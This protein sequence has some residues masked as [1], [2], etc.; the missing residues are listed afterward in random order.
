MNM[1]L[2][3][4]EKKTIQIVAQLLKKGG[5]SMD[6]LRLTKLMYLIDREALLRW[7]MPLTGDDYA[8]MEFG[9]VLSE[10][11]KLTKRRFLG[12]RLWYDYIS[13]EDGNYTISLLAD[14]S[15][16]E[17]SEEDLDLIDEI[18]T[19]YERKSN[20]F[21]VNTVHHQLPEWEN[22]GKSSKMIATD[23]HKAL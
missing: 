2:K 20:Y 8:S 1:D 16:G 6:M 7:G 15:D 18:Y 23:R 21:L 17:L 22:V 10:T 4:D 3:Y 19:K 11:Y 13:A 14:P 9:M 12:Y 5:G